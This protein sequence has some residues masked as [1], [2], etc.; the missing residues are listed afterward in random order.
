MPSM[1]L[2][3]L[4]LLDPAD[5]TNAPPG[6][7]AG[8]VRRVL[9]LGTGSGYNAGLLCALYG[10]S[11]VT[12]LE[13]DPRLA[14]R[15]TR[16]LKTAGYEPH[17]LVGDAS[18]QLPGADGPFDVIEATFSV[19]HIPAP[20]RGAVRPGGRIVTPW[21][22]DWCAYATL[23]LDVR[24]DGGAEGSFHPFGAYM[25]MRTPTAAPAAAPTPDQT[26]A[27]LRSTAEAATPEPGSSA[28]T[29]SA[30]VR[31]STALSPWRVV[32]GDW[33]AEFHLGLAVP[34]VSYEWD[35]TGEHAA[36]RLW[37]THADG[38]SCM[39]VSQRSCVAP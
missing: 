24:P 21:Y 28:G 11:A 38:L 31:G 14:R 37:L 15:A 39:P 26:A 23:A 18:T 10:Q 33:D 27:G 3:A 6:E 8:P 36:A 34:H 17:V 22:S 7:R 16:A 25:T 32:G 19:D 13:I 35:T 4:T 29:G 5:L 12:T 1:V 9:E 20:W 2:R 30:S